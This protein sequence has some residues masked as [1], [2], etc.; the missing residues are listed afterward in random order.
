MQAVRRGAAPLS[1]LEA[2]TPAR[3]LAPLRRM[4][5]IAGPALFF[6]LAA[7]WFVVV[8]LRNPG[9]ADFFFVHEHFQRYLTDQAR[10]PGAV[11]YFVPLLLAGFDE[12]LIAYK[13]RS[14]LLEPIHAPQVLTVNGIFRPI[15][16]VDGRVAGTWQRST[17][18]QGGVELRPFGELPDGVLPTLTEAAEAV[19]RF[20]QP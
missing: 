1:L 3:T 15:L 13:D 11:W 14:Q 17:G 12:Y 5:W 19:E 7:P 8:S 10:R 18:K 9:F 4:H 20:Y 16:V 2:S 6:A